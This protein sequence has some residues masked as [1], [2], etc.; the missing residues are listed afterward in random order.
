MKTA[1]I[2]IRYSL[3]SSKS[4]I[5]Q[6]SRFFISH[7]IIV[8][9]VVQRICQ[10]NINRYQIHM[11]RQEDLQNWIII[12]KNET[13]SFYLDDTDH[14]EFSSSG[15]VYFK[16]MVW[17]CIFFP[18]KIY[19]LFLKKCVDLTWNEFQFLKHHFKTGILHHKVSFVL[20]ILSEHLNSETD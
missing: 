10:F 3:C 12:K 13:M 8:E 17:D 5:I 1:R 15:T 20:W 4:K 19:K 16:D 11:T 6:D 14:S 7:K 9:T 2:L 18:S